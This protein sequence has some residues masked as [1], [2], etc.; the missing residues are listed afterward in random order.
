VPI[1]G[2][3]NCIPNHFQFTSYPI[4]HAEQP[5]ILAASLN[6][7]KKCTLAHAVKGSSCIVFQ[8]GAV[9][10]LL[11]TNNQILEQ[12]FRHLQNLTDK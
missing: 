7:Q 8:I 11:L 4:L 5:W 3:E 12:I 6:K 9:W 1:L 10:M 2:S